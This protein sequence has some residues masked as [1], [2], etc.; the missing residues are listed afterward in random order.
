MLSLYVI[1]IALAA[2]GSVCG[3]LYM[4]QGWIVYLAW[5]IHFKTP[6]LERAGAQALHIRCGDATIKVWRLHPDRR[7]ALLYFGG[8]AED[9]SINLAD[10]DTAFADRAVYLVNYRG[11]AGST[12]RPS[13][14]RLIR[15]AKSIFDWVAARHER[16]VVVGK[17]LGSGIATALAARRKVE[18]L[19]LVTPYDTL[20]NVAADYLPF[21]PVRWLLRDRYE[22]VQRITHVRAPVL[23]VLAEKDGLVLKPRSDALIA[24]IQAPLRHVRVIEG[25]AHTDIRRF[26]EYFKSLKEFASGSAPGTSAGC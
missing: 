24:A 2:Y 1:L 13:E 3:A 26:P 20:T 8:S 16:I 11:Y 14:A 21:L 10:F 23:V 5:V 19:M 12:G 25:A 9:V 17:S 15:D 7:P 18:K 6:V 4:G 22:S